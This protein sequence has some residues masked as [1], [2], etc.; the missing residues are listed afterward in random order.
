M[1]GPNKD[2]EVLIRHLR[3]LRKGYCICKIAVYFQEDK[4][5]KLATKLVRVLS[6][7]KRLESGG[8]GGGGRDFE[9]EELLEDH[10]HKIRELER[11]NGQLKDKLMVTRQQLLSVSSASG[12]HPNTPTNS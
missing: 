2:S 4:I 1:G 8:G 11:Q 3:V 10:Q 9:T 6:D 7:K 12:Q 5:K